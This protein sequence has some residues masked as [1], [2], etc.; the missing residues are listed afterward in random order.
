[1]TLG[2]HWVGGGAGNCPERRDM[3]T[4]MVSSSYFHKQ[5][6]ENIGSSSWKEAKREEKVQSMKGLGS[7]C[8][9]QMF[10]FS[11]LNVTK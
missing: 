7:P 3:E 9:K 11:Y 2:A 8:E 5:G 1:M 10:I 6:E 4:G